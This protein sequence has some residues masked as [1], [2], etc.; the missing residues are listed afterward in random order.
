M[1]GTRWAIRNSREPTTG[2]RSSDFENATRYRTDDQHA[3]DRIAVCRDILELDPTMRGLNAE[4]RLRRSS[5]L[6]GMTTDALHSCVPLD[7]AEEADKAAKK[8][9]ADFEARLDLAGKLWQARQN[10]CGT[11]PEAVTLTLNRLSQ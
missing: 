11:V 7:L 10:G 5:Q 3:R 9:S 8:R 4:E 2:R 6:L 1:R